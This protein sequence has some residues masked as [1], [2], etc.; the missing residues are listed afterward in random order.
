MQALNK[1]RMGTSNRGLDQS[2]TLVFTNIIK[3]LLFASPDMMAAQVTGSS[4]G[5]MYL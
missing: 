1:K 5:D 2:L 4:S 3:R